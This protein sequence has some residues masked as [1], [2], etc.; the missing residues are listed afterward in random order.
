M[1]YDT[2]ISS[3]YTYLEANKG[4][5]FPAIYYPNSPNTGKPQ[6]PTGN[7]VMINI[8]PAETVSIGLNECDSYAGIIQFS[9][10]IKANTGQIAAAD[11][12]NTI[13][14][15]FARNTVVGNGLRIDRQGSAAAGFEDGGWY[16]V[17]VSIE[18]RVFN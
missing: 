6:P 17:P 8:L 14:A 1:I 11:I 12:A 10:R 9:V 3:I 15:I 18:Y 5:G 2:I 4:V 7:H 13:L 16:N